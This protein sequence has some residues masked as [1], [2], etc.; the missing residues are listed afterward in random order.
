M[1]FCSHLPLKCPSEYS[2]CL[3]AKGHIQEL[4]MGDYQE[5]RGQHT[6]GD[7][8]R[9]L[10]SKVSDENPTIVKSSFGHSGSKSCPQN[11]YNSLDLI[12]V[13]QCLFS[14]RLQQFDHCYMNTL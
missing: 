10:S 1:H 14:K 8:E 12:S 4:H 3:P 13:S 5:V 11:L 9:I 2:G 7:R 6:V